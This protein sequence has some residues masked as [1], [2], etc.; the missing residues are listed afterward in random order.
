MRV[1]YRCGTMVEDGLKYC[2][3]CQAPLDENLQSEM[4]QPIMEESSY[5]NDKAETVPGTKWADFLGYFAFWVGGLLN[6]ISALACFSDA[7]ASSVYIILGLI[8]VAA[9]VLD[10]VT[11]IKIIKRKRDTRQFVILAY[12]AV[13][14]VNIVSILSA[15]NSSGMIASQVAGSVVA[16]IMIV[17]NNIYFMNRESIFVN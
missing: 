14:L 17:V 3:S 2:P 11:A 12:S 10:F 13:I 16:V 5:K 7:G 4:P 8:Y 6:I 15:I 9:C 1:C